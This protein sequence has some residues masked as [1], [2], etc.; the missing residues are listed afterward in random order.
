MLK[1]ESR[2]SSRLGGVEKHSVEDCTLKRTEIEGIWLSSCGIAPHRPL[3]YCS[4]KRNPSPTF[5]ALLS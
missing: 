2:L 5:L 3:A 4:S 1:H